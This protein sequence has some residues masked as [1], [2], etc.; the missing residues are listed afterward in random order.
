M[1]GP[2]ATGAG[3]EPNAAGRTR[4][5]RNDGQGRMKRRLRRIDDARRARDRTASS[6][7]SGRNGAQ[8]A[9]L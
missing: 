3:A 6:S 7:Q 4:L 5:D 2:R 1:K 8:K 9:A